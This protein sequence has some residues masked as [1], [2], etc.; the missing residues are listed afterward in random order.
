[1]T[2]PSVSSLAASLRR[3]GET[4]TLE[5]KAAARGLPKSILPTLSAFANGEGGVVLLG[6]D[7][8]SGFVPAAGFDAARTANLL[9]EAAVREL[10]PPLRLDIS[11]EDFEDGQV[12][13]ARVHEIPADAKPCHL[14]SRG[15]RAGSYV[16][17]HEG[18]RLLTDYENRALRDNRGQPRHDAEAT[19][20]TVD[21][22]DSDAVAALLRRARSRQP[23]IFRDAPDE[24]VLRQLNVL[25]PSQGGLVPSLAGLLALGSYPQQ[26]HPQLHVSFVSV[27][28]ES[29]GAG[30]IN[31]PRFLDSQTLTGPLPVMI[32]DAVAAVLRNSAVAAHVQGVGREDRLDYP[33]DVVR[34]AIVNAVMHRDLGHHG[35]GTQVQVEMY[36]DRLD[37]LS[38]GGLFGP[39][40][41]EDL[42]EV[43]SSRNSRLAL[44]LADIELPGT[45]RVVCENRGSGISVMREVMRREG[46]PE[47]EFHA[48]LTR[49]RTTL[50]RSD[51]SLQTMQT[52]PRRE[53]Q[54]QELLRIL[55]D[56]KEYA[57][58]DLEERIGVQR[59]M[60]TRYLNQLIDEGLIEAT[61][62]PRDRRRRYRTT[63]GR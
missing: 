4:S 11:I 30:P 15:E 62:P 48:S 33:V 9:D 44:L 38:P 51:S 56:G 43:S 7:E 41:N 55:G 1:M 46:R 34:E 31:G 3:H 28:G 5:A 24:V 63:S 53:E 25:V 6:L 40:T 21:D 45:G 10:S 52:T 27:P 23:R 35:R 32:E 60:L 54:L 47:P 12:V 50:R 39:V 59:A 19:E 57:A 22:L 61:A 49:F 20:A 14:V 58:A 13:M 26:F 8:Q 2:A 37:I 36:T 42:G 16:R 18:D 17:S 29:K